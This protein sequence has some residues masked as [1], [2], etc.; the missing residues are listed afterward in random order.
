MELKFKIKKIIIKLEGVSENSGYYVKKRSVNRDH[1][2]II[3]EWDKFG[4]DSKLDRIDIKY[5]QEI[6]V[7]EHSRSHCKSKGNILT[8]EVNLQAEE[9]CMLH[10]FPEF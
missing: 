6:C 3:D 1:G 10:I 9:F 4:N 7:P 5:L 2:S 8:L